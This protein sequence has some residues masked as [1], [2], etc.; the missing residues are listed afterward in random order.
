MGICTAARRFTSIES[1]FQPCKIYRDCPM[2]RNQGKAKCGLKNAHS[3]HE[4]V[5]N[6]SLATDIGYRYI[7]EMVED[8]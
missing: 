6:Q 7:S 8:R 3:L 5:E 2:G 1:S 4:T